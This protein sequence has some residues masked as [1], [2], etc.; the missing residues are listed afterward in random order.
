[1]KRFFLSIVVFFTVGS[2]MAQN[3]VNFKLT[4]MGTF[5]AED[6]Q[7]YK[8]IE[9]NGKSATE[10]YSMIKTNA[11]K[12]YKS[13]KDVL[14]ENE[15][16]TLSIRALTEIYNGYKLP[17][18]F[19][20]YNAFYNLLFHFKDGRIKVDAPIIDQRLDVV[21]TGAALGKS[22][23]SYVDDWFDKKGQPKSKH[24]DEVNRIELI[25]NT[26]INDLL[27]NPKTAKDEE[28]W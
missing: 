12:I 13:P 18:G 6:G 20:T 23:K 26:I 7:S 16:I 27:G 17:G 9:I 11:T 21:A 4:P 14:S 22:F 28:D 2:L 25:F 10:L 24:V 19:I 1:M 5:V 3:T 8:I 15:P